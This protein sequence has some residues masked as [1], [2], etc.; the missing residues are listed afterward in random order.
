MEKKTAQGQVSHM[1][2]YTTENK[3]IVLHREDR[4]ETTQGQLSQSQGYTTE[5]NRKIQ[6]KED[7]KQTV[8][9]QVSHRQGSS[10][11]DNRNI[12]RREDKKKLHKDEYLTGKLPQLKTTEIYPTEKI[13]K[14]EHKVN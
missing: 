2:G 13:E 4:K 8:Q 6:N 12:S 7:R 14:K 9:G 10:T 5:D 3:R 11:E 1:Q